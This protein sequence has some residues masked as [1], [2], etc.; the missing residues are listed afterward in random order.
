MR[1]E[2]IYHSMAQTPNLAPDDRFQ[3][4]CEHSHENVT[5]DADYL[6]STDRAR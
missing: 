3:I 2:V 6:G 5:I 4:L 1:G